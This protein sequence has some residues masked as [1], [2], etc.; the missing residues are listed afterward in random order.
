L[1]F[2]L[3]AN[4]GK[5]QINTKVLSGETKEYWISI[6]PSISEFKMNNNN[7]EPM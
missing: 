2:G 1:I 6:Y 3:I 5:D 7:K 4:N